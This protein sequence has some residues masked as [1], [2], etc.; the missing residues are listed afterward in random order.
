MNMHTRACTALHVL[1]GTLRAVLTSTL[2][3]LQPSVSCDVTARIKSTYCIK[4]AADIPSACSVE[5]NLLGSL[6]PLTKTFC[7]LNMVAFLESTKI[8]AI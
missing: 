8:H 1:S 5:S 4:H 6:Y 2:L 7:A 3:F